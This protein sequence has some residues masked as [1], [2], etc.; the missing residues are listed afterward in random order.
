M[1][2]EKYKVLQDSDLVEFRKVDT[3]N[4]GHRLHP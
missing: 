1:F 2:V 4:Q 3:E